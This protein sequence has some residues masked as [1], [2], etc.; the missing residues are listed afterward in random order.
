MFYRQ[1]LLSKQSTQQVAWIPEEFATVGKYLRI[2][3]SNGWKVEAL[4]SRKHEDYVLWKERDYVNA[5][6]SLA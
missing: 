1:C 5:F 4:Y 6:P 3:S 2:G